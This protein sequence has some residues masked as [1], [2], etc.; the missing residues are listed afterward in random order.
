MSKQGG[1]QKVPQNCPQKEKNGDSFHRLPSPSGKVTSPQ[2]GLIAWITGR[3][4]AVVLEQAQ[5]Q[6][7]R[8]TG[9]QSHVTIH[10]STDLVQ[11]PSTCVTETHQPACSE[12]SHK[13][14][15]DN[16]RNCCVLEPQA[17]GFPGWISPAFSST[18]ADDRSQQLLFF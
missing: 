11:A 3:V 15:C 8:G 6:G 1:L 2:W 10:S 4:F 18:E 13:G 12:L 7:S 9:T 14:C 17:A 5:R 16:F